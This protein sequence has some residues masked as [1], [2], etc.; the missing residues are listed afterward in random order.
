M[1]SNSETQ[2]KILQAATVVFLQRGKKG[3]R[4]QDIARQANMN[5]ALLHYYFRSKE[6]LYQEV[7][8]REVKKV[9]QDLF[10]SITPGRDIRQ[11]LRSFIN[12]YVDRLAENPQVLRFMLW[13]I[14]DGGEG[15]Q[16]IFTDIKSE[17]GQSSPR[18]FLRNLKSAIQEGTIRKVDPYH[19]L[20]NIMGMCLYVFIA[21]PILET[22]F[23]EIDPTTPSF[24]HKRK[25]EIFNL[26][27]SGIKL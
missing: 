13:E 2:Q 10:H 14:E 22:I 9:M 18:I 20:F 1:E 27:W 6:R 4:M 3:A 11:F 19:L 17:L 23:P 12:Q 26:V 5:K 16:H 8:N 21:R 7:F 15:V 24:I 25:E